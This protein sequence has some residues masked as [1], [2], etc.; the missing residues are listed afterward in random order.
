[1]VRVIDVRGLRTREARAQVCYCGRAFAGWPQSRWHNPFP[2]PK[3]PDALA[4]FRDYLAE[5]DARHEL[6]GYL[7]DLWEACGRGRL[8]LGCWCGS[9]VAGDGSEVR[10]HAQIL[11]E[12]LLDRFAS[13]EVGR[14]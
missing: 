11:A 2:A 10:C 3:H 12:L 1:M 14:A 6:G 9:F 5:M 8:P 7:A 13:A 4:K